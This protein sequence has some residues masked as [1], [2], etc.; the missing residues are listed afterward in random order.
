MHLKKFE[1]FFK[2]NE[3][4]F[5]IVILD[6]VC[7]Q[8]HFEALEKFIHLHILVKVFHAITQTIKY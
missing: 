7:S 6:L 8:D 1:L 2:L 3:L 5:N 4:E